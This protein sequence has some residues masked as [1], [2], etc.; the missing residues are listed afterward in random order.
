MDDPTF[1]PF[2]IANSGDW[3]TPD[4]NP[5]AKGKDKSFTPYLVA[6]LTSYLKSRLNS[7]N[8]DNNK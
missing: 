3:R 6:S 4:F 2:T 1:N 8:K 5:N 7:N